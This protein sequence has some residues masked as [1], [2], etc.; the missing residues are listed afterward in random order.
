MRSPF[1]PDNVPDAAVLDNQ[2]P[3]IRSLEQR[4]LIR[5]GLSGSSS[6]CMDMSLGC[7]LLCLFGSDVSD[8]RMDPLAIVIAFDIGEQIAPRLIVRVP[9]TLPDELDLQRM[10]E[11]FHWHVVVA[12]SLPAHRRDGAKF[13]QLTAICARSVSGGFKRSSQHRCYAHG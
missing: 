4:G 6:N 5:G 12:A 7:H 10:E 13:G 2:R 11:A 3:L 1:R 9:P 8:G